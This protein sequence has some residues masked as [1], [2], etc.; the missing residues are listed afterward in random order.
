MHKLISYEYIYLIPL[1]LS[2]I[3]SL[4]SFGRRWPWPYRIFSIYLIITFMTEVFAISWKWYFYKTAYWKYS[5]NN[6]WIY[7]SVYILGYFLFVLFYSRMLTA[8]FFKKGLWYFVVPIIVFGWLDYFF[9]QGPLV[10]N[11]YTIIL[12]NISCILLSLSFFRQILKNE[13]PI[14]LAQHPMVWISL[15]SFLYFSGSLP[16]FIFFNYMY[17]SNPS[18]AYSL[19]YLNNALNVILYSSFLIAFLCK[20][21]PK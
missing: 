10:M 20:P 3:F 19:L 13:E 17:K 8:P 18:L 5:Q 9:I 1:L 4:R 12:T 16:F 11:N 14:R 2:A 21:S 7:N 6:H 15:G